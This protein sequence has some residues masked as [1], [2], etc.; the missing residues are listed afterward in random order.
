NITKLGG[1]V[2]GADVLG[3]NLF[4]RTTFEYRQFWSRNLRPD[5]RFDAPRPVV[6]VRARYGR[7]EG[8]VPFFEQLFVGGVNSL[9]GYDNQ[10][11]WGSQSLLATAEYRYPI[12]RSFNL[13]GFVD[14]GGAWGGYG[15]LRDYAQSATPD[16]KLGYGFGAGFRTPLGPIR[17]DFGFNQDGGSRTHFSFGT[18][19]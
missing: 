4:M 19:F 3:A 5:E 13:V 15:T 9:R 8:N 14:Y 7:I 18:S 11:F 10:R 6:A 16:L 2:S 12:Q 17:I 1:G